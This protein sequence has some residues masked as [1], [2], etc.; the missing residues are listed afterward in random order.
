M[1]A[2]QQIADM[3]R[4]LLQQGAAPDEIRVGH[5]MLLEIADETKDANPM[6]RGRT[7][8][9][10]RDEVIR[11]ARAGKCYL[12]GCRVVYMPQEGRGYCPPGR[13]HG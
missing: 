1:S 9:E 13:A 4:Q 6:K 12:Y 2:L 3:R 10:W 11:D 7:Q 8:Q 5:D